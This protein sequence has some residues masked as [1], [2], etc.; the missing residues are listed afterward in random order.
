DDP[1]ERSGQSGT[2]ISSQS[3]ISP[4]GSQSEV[5]EG[6][7]E[8]ITLTRVIRSSAPAR[9]YDAHRSVSSTPARTGG[10]I[11]TV[12]SPAARRGAKSAPLAR[13]HQYSSRQGGSVMAKAKEMQ[14]SE[15]SRQN[16]G[17]Q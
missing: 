10:I 1:R 14:E 8:R 11:Q 16:Q 2:T 12:F 15:S 7:E 6:A 9:A 3:G 13:P 17:Q 5:K 4:G